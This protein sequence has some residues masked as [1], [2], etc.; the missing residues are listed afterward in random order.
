M[1][2]ELI[3]SGNPTEDRVTVYM[4]GGGIVGKAAAE[5]FLNNKQLSRFERGVYRFV[6]SKATAQNLGVRTRPL[7]PIEATAI[8]ASD[9]RTA[10]TA[11]TAAQT[12][13]T[14]EIMTANTASEG[15]INAI[16]A[17]QTRR[18]NRRNSSR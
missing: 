3:A 9:A 14:S 18:R 2:V 1:K 16:P 10:R 5:E 12:V 7:T 6:I 11:R 13:A 8:T 4:V 15:E 17:P